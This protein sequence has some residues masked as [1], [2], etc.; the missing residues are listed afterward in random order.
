MGGPARRPPAEPVI[1]GRD[2]E[3]VLLSAF[4]EAG[5]RA[6]RVPAAGGAGDGTGHGSDD[7]INDS[8]DDYRGVSQAGS[9][10]A[11]AAILTGPA[12]IGKTA[13]WEWTLER[14]SRLGYLVLAARAG[15]AE[16]QLPW[17]G[18]T[19]LLRTAAEPVLAGLPPP[20][21]QALQVAMLQSD[22]GEAVDE[23]AVGTALWSVLSAQA[24]SGPVLIALDDLPYMDAASA[25]ALRFALRRMEPAS[26]VRLVATARG[27][28]S[29]WAPL[30]GLPGDRVLPVG[31]GP[32]SV[33]ALFEL[34]AA[35]LAVRLARPV[36]LR[37]HVTSGGNP[38]YALELARALD[39]LE[40]V[41]R[42]G[43][44]LPVPT[45]LD[46]LVAERVRS[47]PPDVLEIAA[48]TAAS[49]RFTD[50]GLD[51][52]A[53]HRAVLTGLVVVDEPPVLGGPQIVRAA[54]PLV[55]A[56]AYAALPA[57]GRRALHQR[58][59]ADTDDP[60]D[61]ARH[62]ALAATRADPQIA[63]ALDAGVAA[64]LAAGA[65]DIAV[66]LSRLAL[67]HTDA[68]ADRAARLDLL[69]DALVR[70]G[71]SPGAVEAQRQS[72]SLTPEV[73]QRVRRRIRLAEMATEVIGW[74]GAAKEL[75]AAVA[76]A[77][78]DPVVR[79]E[80]L[81]T[82]AAVSDD[83]DL[84]DTCATEAVALL[85][86]AGQPDPTVLS[87]ALCQAAGARFRAGRGL[88]HDMFRRAID[89]ER[90]HP[91]RRLSDRA[92]AS[93]AALLKYADDLDGAET[94]LLALLAEARAS[95]D[96]SSIAYS[97]GHLPQIALWRGQIA[98]A[99]QLAEEH[100]DVAEQGSLAALAGQARQTLGL[101]MIYE[102]RLDEATGMLVSQRDAAIV[103]N[104]ER[105][106][107]HGALGFAA[108]SGGDPAAAVVHL[109]RWHAAVTGMHL[110]EPGY[111]R[112]HLDY[113][114]S[115]VATGRL[116]DALAF[117]DHLD[118][119]VTRSGRRSAGTI[120]M[121]GRAMV[122]AAS[123][124]MPEALAAIDRA[125]TWYETSPLRFDR[126][127]T[128]LI[129]GQ[130]HRRVKAKRLAQEALAEAHR[131]FTAF[132]AAAWARQAAAE[133]A[134]VNL[135]PA[136]AGTLTETERRVAELAAAGLTNR[137][138]AQ[139][140]FLAVKTVEAN[141]ARVYRKL[142][143][144]SRAEL[145]ARMGPPRP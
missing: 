38:L 41:P 75:E 83:I 114:T 95:A 99:R 46:E 34:L 50:A 76:E 36:L 25:G 66:E 64:A 98:R 84:A 126:A 30:D 14:A 117:L 145:G 73:P 129:A 77:A 57:V 134:R 74:G 8:S 2:A 121:T 55:S 79:S 120:A 113:A 35:R 72:I 78:A 5:T 96:L 118:D 37:V 116:A 63:R 18:L 58:L 59:S 52:S 20:Q 106:R 111:S 143:I 89:L 65:P 68:D 15:I 107:L 67:Q 140:L 39:R 48:G 97:L 109:D 100:L 88:D 24:Q 49:W 108:L 61:R 139:Q 86:Q 132:G 3:R 104:W 31:V 9:T 103:T 10:E 32:V 16:A 142:G 45:S 1:V 4:L 7:G 71:D 127:R 93:Y 27:D 105:H 51:P 110:R 136:A 131:E 101:V 115:L 125:L 54:H 33:G 102:G 21:R 94:R 22:L 53:L 40:I 123:G 81:L 82:L 137:E 87:G 141:L 130:I 43:V 90:S 135:R 44:P 119:Q 13:L 12:G 124:R 112:W 29:R 42:P 70:A 91:S 23:R 133:L 92:D 60:L 122:D 69:A 138:V 128:L 19:D 11:V 144:A 17:V 56:A 47:V 80:A 26:R 6:W 85:E 62:A 28:G